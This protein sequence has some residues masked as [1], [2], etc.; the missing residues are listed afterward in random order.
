MSQPS[1]DARA[2][3]AAVDRLTTQL[4]AQLSRLAD[5]RQTPTDDA[6][7][8]TD[9]ASPRMIGRWFPMSEQQAEE[10]NERSSLIQQWAAGAVETARADDE[11]QQRTARRRSLRV[12]LNR[13]NRGL[14]LTDAEAQLLTDHV[15]TLIT[16]ANDGRKRAEQAEEL[17]R[18]AHETSNRSEAERARAVQRAEQLAAALRE[19]LALIT[20]ALVNGQYAFYQATDHPIAPEDY[21]RWCAALDGTEQPTTTEA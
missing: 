4:S 19:V 17:Q 6:T 2:V 3:V 14:A 21:R 18:I 5:T 7:T 16:D 8:T 12:L 13:V 10:M 15:T 1:P 9:D 20:P 11:E